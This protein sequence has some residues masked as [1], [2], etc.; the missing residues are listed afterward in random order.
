MRWLFIAVLAML[1]GLVLSITWMNDDSRWPE[2]N[3]GANSQPQ[4]PLA[5]PAGGN[6]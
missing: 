3:G 2:A 5:P 4:N 6:P 1:V